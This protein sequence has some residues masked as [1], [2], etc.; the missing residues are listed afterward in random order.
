M[1]V[2]DD[3]P[4]VLQFARTC[5]ERCGCTVTSVSD[6]CVAEAL[7]TAA[8]DAFD[9]VVT[10]LTMPG[11][12]GW[13]LRQRLHAIRGDVPIVL[14]SG[15][16]GPLTA[17]AVLAQGFAAFVHKPYRPATLCAA[18]VGAAGGS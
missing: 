7:F 12:S 16:P 14:V 17:D 6:P 18:V 10:D 8:P 9:A 13:G 3:E 2:V 1:L 4:G 15:N 11:L 5:L